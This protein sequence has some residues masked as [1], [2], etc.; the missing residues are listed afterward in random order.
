MA[1]V[2]CACAA[3]G[4]CR[5][6]MPSAGVLLEDKILRDVKAKA[7]Q[8]NLGTHLVHQDNRADDVCVRVCATKKMREENAGGERERK[9]ERER[10]R[11]PF[12]LSVQAYP[13]DKCQIRLLW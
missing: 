11:I 7:L 6:K 2:I 4:V 3:D 8:T 13:C 5:L 9:R 10:E 12:Q 1:A